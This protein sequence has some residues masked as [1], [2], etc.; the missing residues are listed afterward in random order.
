MTSRSKPSA[1]PLASGMCVQRGEKVFV[2]RIG[3]AVDALLDR[4]GLFEA[5]P[6]LVRVGQFAERVGELDAADVE[7]ETLRHAWVMRAKSRQ[8]RL[9]GRIL[10]EEG[11]PAE[12]EPRLD[13]RSL[14]IRL[15]TSDHVSSAATRSP[16]AAAWRAN[17]S[18][19]GSPRPSAR[20]RVEEVDAGV[21]EKSLAHGQA[22]GDGEWVGLA[23]AKGEARRARLSRRERQD[24]RAILHQRLQRRADAIPFEHGEF[25][26][27]QG[28]ALAI[29]KHPRE[30]EN[31][32]LAGGEQLFHREFGRRVQIGG[33]GAAVRPDHGRGK[34]VQMR[35]V[36]RRSLQGGGLDLDEP[37]AL[38]MAAHGARRSA[39]ARRA[40]GGGRRGGSGSRRARRNSRRAHPGGAKRQ[41]FVRSYLAFGRE[42]GMVRA[43][44][45]QAEA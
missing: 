19:S 7:L 21:P 22:F 10:G 17:K 9:R 16:I 1:A 43:A 28:A 32:R 40:A 11:R 25:R 29:A 24:A 41:R 30:R 12:A 5:P 38:E 45:A 36:A 26:R 14:R 44:F 8:R 39:R 3:L 15:K 35:L 27:V 13:L 4:H 18:R 34:P 31:A 23:A 6:L 33:P 2:D 20:Q 37:L 42:I